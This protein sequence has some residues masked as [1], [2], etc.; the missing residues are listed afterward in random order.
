M[1]ESESACLRERRRIEVKEGACF[2]RHGTKY[3]RLH[4]AILLMSVGVPVGVSVGVP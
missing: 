2:E 1:S 3:P 4:D